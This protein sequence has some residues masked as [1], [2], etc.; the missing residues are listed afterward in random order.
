MF[1]HRR[2]E[3]TGSADS[4]DCRIIDRPG[5]APIPVIQRRDSEHSA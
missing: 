2:E 3:W 1:A 5:Y 4:V